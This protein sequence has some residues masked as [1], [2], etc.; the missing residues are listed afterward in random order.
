MPSK[1]ASSNDES[2]FE[3]QECHEV[4]VMNYIGLC[5]AFHK[6]TFVGVGSND[7]ADFGRYSAFLCQA[8]A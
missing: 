6:V 4:G 2:A 7:M 1:A 5:S 3:R 8:D